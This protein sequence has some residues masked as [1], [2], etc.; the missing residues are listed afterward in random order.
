[1]GG[2][3]SGRKPDLIKSMRQQEQKF[4]PI[5]D[6]MFIPNYSGVQAAALRTAPALG[7][8]GGGGLNNVVEDTS[9]QLGGNLQ[10]NGFNLSGSTNDRI[11]LC[12]D[13]PTATT[14]GLIQ[15]KFDDGNANNKAK[16]IIAYVDANDSE[17][18]W[19]QAHDWLN[20]SNQH[21][22]FSIE[23]SDNA[24]LKQTRLSVG[25]GSDIVDVNTN[26]AN[27]YING[28]GSTRIMDADYAGNLKFTPYT[29]MDI[30]P[31]SQASRALRISDDGADINF[32]ILGSSIL[33]VNDSIYSTGIISGSTGV[34]VGPNAVML[35]A[36]SALF[37][38][39]GGA[40]VSLGTHI[41]DNTDPHSTHLTQT[42]MTITT[43]SGANIINTGDHNTSGSAFVVGVIMDPS[44]TPPTASN[45]PMGTLYIQYTA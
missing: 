33:R 44:P 17:V 31:N 30:Y 4:V 6:N 38:L 5:A 11:L 7:T 34:F 20:D 43:L 18:I 26:Q 1:M 29:T 16:A 13:L 3:G 32:T 45:Y 27:F 14:Q 23:A 8:G 21:K 9:P 15:L 37:A 28:S 39:S 24:G 41:S 12:T 36:S 35:S 19:L 2:D 22:H 40:S 10:M 25:Y 42:G